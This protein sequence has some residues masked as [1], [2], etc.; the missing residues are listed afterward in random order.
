MSA[1]QA[2]AGRVW[3]RRIAGLALALYAALL[4]LVFLSPRSNTQSD[5]VARLVSELDRLGAS[6]SL[7]TYA[8]AEVLMNAVIVVPLTFLGSLVLRRVRWQDWTA[9]AFLGAIAV[10]LTQGL[11]LPDRQASFSDI[12]ANTVGALVGALLARLLRRDHFRG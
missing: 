3:A 5:L 1:T 11:L 8:R 9:Y 7:V 4:A 10:E 2:A 12:V 6:E